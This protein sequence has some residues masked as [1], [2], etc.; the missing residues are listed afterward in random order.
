M[1]ECISKFMFYMVRL[2]FCP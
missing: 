1:H 2:C